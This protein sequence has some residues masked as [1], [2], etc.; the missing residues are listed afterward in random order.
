MPAQG[1]T[2]AIPSRFDTVLAREESDSENSSIGHTALESEYIFSKFQVHD[3]FLHSIRLDCCSSA[4][5][6]AHSLNLSHMWNGSRAL[7]IRSL[8]LGCI[9]QTRIGIGVTLAYKSLG[10]RSDSRVRG[11]C[12]LRP[13]PVCED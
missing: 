5:S 11:D 6:M 12:N 4:R 3:I 9:C 8:I 13:V 10:Y 1:L 7:A 2:P